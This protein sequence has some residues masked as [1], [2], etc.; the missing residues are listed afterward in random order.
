MTGRELEPQGQSPG[1]R[2]AQRMAR[3]LQPEGMKTESYQCG[4]EPVDGNR[5]W[6]LFCASGAGD[7]ERVRALLDS[8]PRLVNAQYW[9]QF[10][11]HM[12]VRENHAEVVEL[13][14]RAGADPG[15]SRYTYNSWDKLLAI[16]EE[17]GYREVQALLAS[18][19][20]GRFGYDP[21]FTAMAEAIKGR[22]RGGVEAVLAGH[23]GFIRAA[24]ALGNGPLHWAALTRQNDLVDLFVARGTDLEARRADGQTPLLVSLN[25]DYW[26]RT[27]NLPPEAPQDSWTVTRHLLACGAEYALSIACAAGDE[28]RV[29]AVLAADPAQARDLDDG[30]RS[31][32]SYAA[33]NGHTRIV[34]KLLDL[35]ADPNRPEELAPRGGGLFG[36][37]AGNHPKTAKLLIERGADPNAG[38]DSS[39]TCLTIVEYNH[40]EKGGPMQALLRE[41]GAVTPPYA[42]DDAALE[43]AMRAGEE[44]VSDPQL[45]HEVMGR[46]NPALIGLFLDTTPNAGEL[47]QLT[48]IWGGNYPSDPG[49]IRALADRGVDMRRANW[50]GRTFLHGCAEKGDVAAARVFLE[51][52]ADIEAVEL[53]YEGTPLAAAARKGQAEMVRFLLNQ[54]ADPTAPAQSPWAQP[55]H[56]AE[57]EGH[58][59]VAALLRERRSG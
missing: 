26:Y 48:D 27:R 32:L 23:P 13:L 33:R 21:G 22:D 55:L 53:E 14:L 45:L 12:A 31:P 42:M 54:G 51:L 6:E 25:G 35:G 11:I 2:F 39:G 9:Y 49:T 1:E 4:I 47:F 44:G 41:H 34:E 8:D 24:D 28:D 19:M 3:L 38:V 46:D 50:I 58:G 37:C 10:P 56:W 52:G 20:R 5:A 16:A 59:E 30:R 15:Q 18:A 40:G 57:K 17:R 29:D 43:R 7:L 36:A